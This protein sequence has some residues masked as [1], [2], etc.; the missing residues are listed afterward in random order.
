MELS[1]TL[2]K[3]LELNEAMDWEKYMARRDKKSKLFSRKIFVEYL[4][5]FYE[6][7]LSCMWVFKADKI[8]RQ[9]GENLGGEHVEC[10]AF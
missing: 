5:N 8:A 9:T 6:K 2:N 4:R 3:T 10:M 7:K 1:L